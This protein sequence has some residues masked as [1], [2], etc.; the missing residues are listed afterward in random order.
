MAHW[1]CS[2][3]YPANWDT[4]GFDQLWSQSGQGTTQLDCSIS[5]DNAI[6]AEFTNHYCVSY[7]FLIL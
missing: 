7:A 1:C 5:P 4:P 3:R 6:V 2:G